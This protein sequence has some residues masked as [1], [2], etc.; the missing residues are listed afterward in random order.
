MKPREDKPMS[1]SRPGRKFKVGDPV[2]WTDYADGTEHP[3]EIL[4]CLEEDDYD[5][6]LNGNGPLYAV[7][8]NPGQHWQTQVAEVNLSPWPR[9]ALE[10]V[11]DDGQDQA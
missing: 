8:L 4:E 5:P 10:V 7:R 6:D 3:C 2:I 1:N 9:P 11:S